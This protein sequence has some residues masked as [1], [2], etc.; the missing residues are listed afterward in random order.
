[1]RFHLPKNGA[2]SRNE[3][4]FFIETFPLKKTGSHKC[5]CLRAG[6]AREVVLMADLLIGRLSFQLAT[7]V[8][9]APSGF[10]RAG[11]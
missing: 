4:S 6:C 9:L 7:W 10:L 3:R 1:M 5:D 11:L 2:T 8:R